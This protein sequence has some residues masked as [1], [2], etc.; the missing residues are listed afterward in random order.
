MG[1][2]NVNTDRGAIDR[3]INW[4]EAEGEGENERSEA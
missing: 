4:T 1:L 2:F 3:M